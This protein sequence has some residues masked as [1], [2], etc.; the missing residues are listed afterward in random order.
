MHSRDGGF[1]GDPRPEDP[2]VV[3]FPSMDRGSLLLA[4]LLLGAALAGCG[5]SGSSCPETN[6]LDC[7]NGACCDTDHLFQCGSKC[8]IAPSAAADSGC[9]T[10][11]VCKSGDATVCYADS[12]R[13]VNGPFAS[14]TDCQAWRAQHDQSSACYCR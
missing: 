12:N 1:S 3:R 9:T 7:G 10:S 2:H 13:V 8:W 14:M 6:P 4:C 11:V 5:S